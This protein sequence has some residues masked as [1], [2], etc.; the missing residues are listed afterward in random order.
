MLAI[1]CS[2]LSIY[3]GF[4][5]ASYGS[6]FDL[7]ISMPISDDSLDSELIMLF[8]S[9]ASVSYVKPREVILTKQKREVFSLALLEFRSPFCSNTVEDRI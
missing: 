7:K 5:D 8:R 1:Y 9:D 4:L 2:Q 3:T 6:L